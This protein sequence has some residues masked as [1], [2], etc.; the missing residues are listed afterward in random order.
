MPQPAMPAVAHSATCNRPS[1]VQSTNVKILVAV[2]VLMLGYLQYKLW[3]DE[4]K[5]QDMW[6]LQQRIEQLREENQRLTERN[7]TLEAE[8]QNL[9]EGLD[10]VEERARSELGM[11]GKEETFIQFVDK[12][13]P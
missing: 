11:V 8:V 10:V 1:G 3:V 13:K 6:P 4:G 2:L 9:K 12:E 7:R 5:V